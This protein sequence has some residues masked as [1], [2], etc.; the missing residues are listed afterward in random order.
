MKLFLPFLLY[1]VCRDQAQGARLALSGGTSGYPLSRL[2]CLILT[3]LMEQFSSFLVDT[4]C[5]GCCPALITLLLLC[6]GLQFGACD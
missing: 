5:G 1:V 3:V 4:G 6:L 2:D